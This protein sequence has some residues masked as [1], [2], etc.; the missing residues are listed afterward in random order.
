VNSLLAT[1]YAEL[2]ETLAFSAFDIAV[3]GG[4][5]LHIVMRVC[6]SFCGDGDLGMFG[7]EEIGYD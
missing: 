4:L 5:H 3:P 2:V 1:C 7:D 6:A